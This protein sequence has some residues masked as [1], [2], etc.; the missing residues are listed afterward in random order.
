MASAGLGFSAN[1]TA[2][3]PQLVRLRLIGGI[4]HAIDS[5]LRDVDA[6]DEP[7][8][9]LD[10]VDHRAR[11]VAQVHAFEAILRIPSRSGHI[12]QAARIGEAVE[13]DDPVGAFGREQ[14]FD[15]H[16]V[17]DVTLDKFE[18]GMRL[19]PF[20]PGEPVLVQLPLPPPKYCVYVQRF[21]F[22][23]VPPLY[24]HHC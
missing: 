7:V 23:I 13:V 11:L 10:E 2:R 9:L 5:A 22:D 6:G 16:A 19:E 1:N 18:A 8:D 20:Q 14:V 4:G 3:T 21:A 24:E 12:L 15:H 17:G